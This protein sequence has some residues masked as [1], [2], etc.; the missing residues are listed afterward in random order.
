MNPEKFTEK[1]LLSLQDAVNLASQKKQAT[2]E[3]WHL[4]EA[5]LQQEETLIKPLLIQNQINLPELIEEIDKKINNLPTLNQQAQPQLS[6]ILA[7]IINQAE[8]LTKSWQDDYISSEHLLLAFLET[9]SPAGYLLKDKG[10]QVE[11]INNQIKKLRGNMKVEDKNPETKYNVLE[12][13]GQDFT[14]MAEA[15]QLDPVIGRD[16]EIRRVMQVLSRRTKNNPVLIGEAGVGKTTI[17]EGLAQRIITGDIPEQLKNKKLI[18]LEIGSL[19][20]GAKYRGEFEERLKAV[21]TEVEKSAGQII[22]F[23]DELHTIV[24]AGKAEGAMDAGNMMKPLLARGK[25]RMIGATTL[26]EY[27][28]NIEKDPALERRFQPV[29]V[30]EPGVDDT[31]AILRGLKE[32]YELHHGVRITDQALV[33][34]A[35]LSDRYIADRFLP[36][37]AVDLM[38]EATA[39]VKMAID[40]LPAEL[41]NLRRQETQLEIEKQALKKEKDEASKKRLKE[42]EKKLANLKEKIKNQEATWRHEKDLI[43]QNRQLSEKL[44]NL[45]IKQ[46]QAERNGDYDQAAKIRYDELPATEKEIKTVQKKLDQIPASDRILREEVTDEDIATV[47][48]RWTGIPA[49]RLLETEAEKL[50]KMEEELSQRVIGQIEAISGVSRAVRRARAGL[51]AYNKPIGSFLFLGPT[52][53]GKTELAKALAEYLFNDEHSM[54]R[55]DMSEYMESH[56]VSRLIGSPPGYIGYEEGGQLTEAVRRRPYSVILLDEVEK[57]HPDVFNLLLQVLDDGRLTDSQGRSVNFAN[58]IVIMTSNLASDKIADWPDKD[59][60]GLKTTVMTEVRTH[61]RPEF[62][63]RLDDIIIFTKLNDEE[64]DKIIDLQLAEAATMVAD[65]GIK[66]EFNKS[67]KELVKRHGYDP[68]FGARPLKRAV[69]TLILDELSNAIINQEIKNGSQVTITA[70]K[71]KVKLIKK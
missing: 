55:I 70:D 39:A 4:L 25:L 34:A 44:E 69:Q 32:K 50:S 49:N 21:L 1:S 30:A 3:D 11:I 47:I 13:Y 23:V 22:M 40:S 58:T 7:K 64:L 56:A 43:A 63:N 26:K 38:D 68:A 27:R 61:F 71:D 6:P 33:T 48:A 54:I 65:Q 24:G 29:F 46:E 57:A 37:K 5:L 59:T 8:T 62:L 51:K 53:V 42:I 52:G 28:E 31:I 36:D 12:K 18:G 16:N 17:V 35:S 10:L 60:A 20:A 9:D 2:V 14:K 67:V 19:L 45:K 41:D 66:V 15:G